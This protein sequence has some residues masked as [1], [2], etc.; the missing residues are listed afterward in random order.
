VS[1]GDG[2]IGGGI[3]DPVVCGVEPAVEPHAAQNKVTAATITLHLK[4]VQSCAD[5]A[6][7][8]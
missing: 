2:V 3:V 4:A 1:A 6:P 5:L 8:M 7:S